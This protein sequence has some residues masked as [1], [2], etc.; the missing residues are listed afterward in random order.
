MCNATNGCHT[1]V[2][3]IVLLAFRITPLYFRR[4]DISWLPLS[5]YTYYVGH[6]FFPKSLS[7]R[8]RRKDRE[9]FPRV[10][11]KAA[12]FPSRTRAH[13]IKLPSRRGFP[14]KMFFAGFAR[15]AILT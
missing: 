5:L 2:P 6:D 14:Q 9:T 1:N 3:I 10:D 7:E 4:I 11:F 8:N 12:S 13:L 15:S